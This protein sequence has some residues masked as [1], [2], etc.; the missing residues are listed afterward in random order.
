MRHLIDDLGF[1]AALDHRA[2][3][4]PAHIAEAAPEGV[5]VLFENVGRPS[6]DAALPS[7]AHG[8]RI[9]L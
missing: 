8:G 9:M 6:L 5:K 1:H 2:P 3:D 7:M 4:L